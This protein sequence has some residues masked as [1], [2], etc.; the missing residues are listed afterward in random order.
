MVHFTR[1]LTFAHP[2]QDAL[3]HITHVPC[4]LEYDD[5]R[6]LYDWVVQN[7]SF[8]PNHVRSNLHGL[9]KLYRMSKRKLR[10][11]FVRGIV[12]GWDDP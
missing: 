3:E 4:S 1:C 11:L 6:P 2:N 12:S 7:C 9:D 10:R 8:R 5:H